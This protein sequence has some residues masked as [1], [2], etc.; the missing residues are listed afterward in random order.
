[1]EEKLA[2]LSDADLKWL[3]SIAKFPET[4]TLERYRGA[5]QTYE[6]LE[7]DSEGHVT[8]VARRH[9][10][11]GFVLKVRDPD[12]TLEYAA[13]FCV[14]GDYAERTE[15]EEAQLASKLQRAEGLFVLPTAVGRAA[16]FAG[17]PASQDTHF[18]CFLTAWV[19]G[20]TLEQF[21]VDPKSALTPEFVCTVA[22]EIIRGV[23]FLAAQGLK[24][25][26][27]HAGNVM[28]SEVDPDLALTEAERQRQRVS[29]IDMGSLK[30]LQQ[31]THKSRDD[32]LSVIGILVDMYN[33]LWRQRRIAA[34]YQRFLERF[35]QLI[36]N[37]T[38]DDPTRFYP[39][40]K[41][42]AAEIAELQRSLN[43]PTEA[44]PRTFHP[45]EAI[46]AEHLADDSTLLELFVSS[47]PWMAS[48]QENKPIVFTG[49]RG[50]GKSMLFRFLAART[51]IGV[52]RRALDDPKSFGVYI[53][54]ASQLQNNLSWIARKPGRATEYSQAISTYFQLVVVREF[55]R[56]LG[57]AFLDDTWRAR[58]GITESGLDRVLNKLGVYFS[59]P[60]ET[61]RLKSQLRVLHFADDL[62]RLRVRLHMQLLNSEPP[63]V[64]LPDTFLGDAT[65]SLT[66]EIP[67]FRTYPV[68]FLLDD[69]TASRVQPEIQKTINRII[70]ERRS[71]HYFKISSE[72]Y[73][74]HPEDIDGSSIDLS[75][76][77]DVVDAGRSACDGTV[78]EHQ[79][80]QFLTSLIDARLRKAG[81]SGRT[82]SLIGS[83]G[84]FAS[85]PRL[86]NFIRSKGLGRHNYYYGI[87][88]LSRLWS[89][90]T[91]TVL[92]IVKE[93]FTIGNVRPAQTD[94][95][96]DQSQHLAITNVS[97]AFRERVNSFH[98][99]GPFMSK[100]LDEYAGAVRDILVDGSLDNSGTPR[101]LYRVEMTK[102]ES[103]PTLDLLKSLNPNASDLA[104]E[105]LRRSIFV[106]LQD[107]RGKEGPSTHTMRWDLRRIYLPAFGL[108]LARESYYDVK[109]L[110]KL[111]QLLTE[112]SKFAQEMRQ[113][114]AVG[115]KQ[116]HRSGN[117]FGDQE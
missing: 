76:E 104:R 47:L 2:D 55:L 68:V 54:C 82:E 79:A 29:I 91:A 16:R 39:G 42:R 85:D 24:H 31:P 66:T 96:S 114:Y 5:T 21:L 62:D 81:W 105:L 1:M 22:N 56:A 71:S 58:F 50:C 77:Y 36:I 49:P 110:E 98:P 111:L 52:S 17:M 94:K 59:R 75:R 112:A 26:D 90:D 12:T 7:R 64:V 11:K 84:E 107:S 92:Q 57:A 48:L 13:K 23:H 109:G 113:Q 88:H 44:N 9:G 53:S 51:H 83:S 4:F 69:Y 38:D 25:D 67:L 108:S 15:R 35:R 99:F 32:E 70:F 100:I 86:A 87:E 93:M 46:S 116:D 27:L 72:R 73:G 19:E 65:E 34:A 106:E 74:F 8:S 33:A 101:R 78:T 61:P 45:F 41:F 95:I 43:M 102:P 60:V 20:R 6:I 40:V 63:E 30:P 97:K 37:L 10:Y 80:R 14:V 103:K 115:K 18:V 89:G 3:K 117:L 28:I